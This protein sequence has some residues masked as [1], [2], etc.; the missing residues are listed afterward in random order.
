MSL[1][2][3]AGERRP[4]RKGDRWCREQLSGIAGIGSRDELLENLERDLS[5]G[6]R[7]VYQQYLDW[8]RDLPPEAA[9]VG[10]YLLDQG[11]RLRRVFVHDHHGRPEETDLAAWDVARAVHYAGLGWAARYVTEA[12][13]WAVIARAARIAAG[14]YD[15]WEAFGRGFVYGRWFWVGFWD[16][17]MVATAAAVAALTA[18]GG[19]W[20]D[21]RWRFDVDGLGATGAAEAPVELAPARSTWLA[22][23]MFVDCPAC[24]LPVLVRDAGDALRCDGCGVAS[25]AAHRDAWKHGASP[26]DD[27]EEEEEEEEEDEDDGLRRDAVGLCTNLDDRIQRAIR[28]AVHHAACDRCAAPI[29]AEA[30]RAGAV[31]CGCGA[32]TPVVAAPAWLRAI[33]PQLRFVV[34]GPLAL[35]RPDGVLYLLR[36]EP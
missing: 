26:P 25:E 1:T 31:R 21:L 14:A 36:D 13:A 6:I 10:Y 11:E 35:G 8:H 16:E 28:T 2:G 32:T 17:Q 24:Q 23:R 15:S 12:E 29:T 3:L 19:G 22:V 5:R 9:S 33:D 27:D 7:A 34:G 20:H 4:A 30:A 18:P